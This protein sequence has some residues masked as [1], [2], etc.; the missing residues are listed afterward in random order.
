MFLLSVYMWWN[1]KLMLKVNF[2]FDRTYGY[3][4]SRTIYVL[5]RKIKSTL[6]NLKHKIYCI[7]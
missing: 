2:L 3:K 4:I 7:G 1:A 6:K 5:N